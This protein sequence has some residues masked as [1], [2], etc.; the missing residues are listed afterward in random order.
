MD[1]TMKSFGSLSRAR[2]R[3]AVEW[4]D[5]E[6]SVRGST[7]ATEKLLGL[8]VARQ[9]IRVQSD[10]VKSA[11]EG[12]VAE[13]SKLAELYSDL[14]KEVYKPV[15]GHWSKAG[16]PQVSYR[17][18]TSRNPEEPGFCRG[19]LLR[20]CDAYFADPQLRELACRSG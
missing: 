10:Y 9:G 14:A 12:F 15:E 6:A 1:A 13:S 17:A 5:F 2:R 18:R 7:A 20:C 11:Y 8:Q 16:H 4:A 19:M 3:S